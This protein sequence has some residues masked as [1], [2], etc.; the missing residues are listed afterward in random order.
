MTIP[1]HWPKEQHIFVVS[2]FSI[3][4]STF[5]IVFVNRKERRRRREEGKEKEEEEK[6]EYAISFMRFSNYKDSKIQVS[7]SVKYRSISDLCT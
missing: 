4:N 2:N 3:L 1:C 7:K 6:E 5:W